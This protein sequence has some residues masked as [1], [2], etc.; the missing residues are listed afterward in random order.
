MGRAENEILV[1]RN[2]HGTGF[3]SI[4]F[5]KSNPVRTKHFEFWLAGNAHSVSTALVWHSC[6]IILMPSAHLLCKRSHLVY[7][8]G[9]GSATVNLVEC[10]SICSHFP[11]STGDM[12]YAAAV[13]FME[14]SHIILYQCVFLRYLLA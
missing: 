2:S 10:H 12:L 7:L 14:C 8:A 11:D 4:Q 13:I 5:W 6:C 1:F 9:A 3:A